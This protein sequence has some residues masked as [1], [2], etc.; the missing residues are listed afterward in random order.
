MTMNSVASI[1]WVLICCLSLQP[2]LG[3]LFLLP[4]CLI[5][6]AAFRCIWAR[7]AVCRLWQHVSTSVDWDMPVGQWSVILWNLSTK[8]LMDSLFFCFVARR[9]SIAT[10]VSSLMKQVRNS[11][12]KLA[13]VLIEPAGNFMNHLKATPLRVP[14]NKRIMIALNRYYIPSLRFK[15]VYV[16]VRWPYIVKSM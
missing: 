9:I 3:W 14:M 12:S 1:C 16:L 7:C 2:W 11:F 13:Q 4:P 15:V 6:P 8:A 5:T 10:S